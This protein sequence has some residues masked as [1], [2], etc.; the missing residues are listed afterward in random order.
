MHVYRPHATFGLSS[1][2]ILS[3]LP[4]LQSFTLRFYKRHQRTHIPFFFPTVLW[5]EVVPHLQ[6]YTTLRSLHI[7]F[8]VA[9]EDI[10]EIKKI[11]SIRSL[12]LGSPSV[13]FLDG[14]QE[15]LASWTSL[16]I[17]DSSSLHHASFPLA[18]SLTRLDIGPGHCLNRD[19]L[20]CL[21]TRTP[22]LRVLNVFYD[23]FASYA[24]LPSDTPIPSLHLEYLIV[25][26]QGVASR[27][28]YN[29]LFKWIRFIAPPSLGELRVLGIIADD[30][31]SCPPSWTAPLVEYIRAQQNLKVVCTPTIGFKQSDFDL[32][33]RMPS[34]RILALAY[35][36]SGSLCF[37]YF[38]R[39]DTFYIKHMHYCIPKGTLDALYVH[40]S[41]IHPRITAEV[42]LVRH[43]L[44]GTSGCGGLCVCY[45]YCHHVQ[46]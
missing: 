17:P 13:S 21:L 9:E 43:I 7:L 14:Y 15:Q 38:L 22:A 24:A 31:R 5:K 27:P 11:P 3:S 10:P 6:A 39:S 42:G 35:D 12:T 40:S 16:Q 2:A 1:V 28:T 33:V 32:V 8:R 18:P 30:E 41:S 37:F 36:V 46:S 4:G 26:H 23:N 29:D 20:F 25:R 44:D 19:D 45:R 34:I